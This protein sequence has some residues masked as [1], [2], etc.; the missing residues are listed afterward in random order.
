VVIINLNK[1]NIEIIMNRRQLL[2]FSGG[3]TFATITAN[4]H[5]N[6]NALDIPQPDIEMQAITYDGR[7]L[8]HKSLSQLY[9]LDLND[10]PLPRIAPRIQA[11]TFIEKCPSIPF[12]IALKL[13]VKGFGNVALYA[14]NQG[15]GYS[16]ADFPLNLNLAFAQT[17]IYRV[18]T[19]LSQWQQQGF[20]FP[21]SI[22]TRIEKAED[23]L[24]KAQSAENRIFIAKWCN[25]SLVESLWAG[26]EAVFSQSQQAIHRQNSRPNFLFGCNFF[27]H[28]QQGAEYDRKFQEL[29]NFAT[30]PFY[31]RH[32][33]PQAGQP[34]FLS[35]DEQ[36]NWLNQAKIIPKGHP[37]VWFHPI[38]IPEWV[39]GKTYQEMKQLIFQRVKNIT[40][41]Y[42]QKIPYYDIINEPH[43]ISWAN[44][45]NYS[46]E[47][48]LELTQIAAEASRQGNPEVI[49]I[50]NN[51][52]LWAQNVPY[53]K[54][55][56]YSPYSYL[57]ACLAAEIPFEVIGLQLYYPDQDMLEINRLLERFSI[58]G[59]PIHITELG[60]SSGTAIDETAFLKETTGLWHQPWSETVQAEWIEQF[61]TLCYSKLYIKAISW[62]D[63]ID[64]QFWPHGGLLRQDLTP[65]PSFER[66]QQLIKQWSIVQSQESGVRFNHL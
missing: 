13:A 9:F 42:G 21:I 20:T 45:L 17:R 50:I 12:A 5:L 10:E 8:D 23:Y 44:D 14:D 51:C 11:G 19:A 48:F 61:Y 64:G 2:Q 34:N 57:K 62:W 65:K 60:V 37:L 6:L 59:K 29:F 56:Q 39:R 52:C 49:R 47:Q 58:L 18:K 4:S 22:T 33:E 66:L 43:G 30:V 53:N 36:V 3:L 40:A 24:K 38:G 26:E 1:I 28:P 54:P 63:L 35:L 25:D 55:P 41:H 31:W 46:Q 7:I 32:F 27:G 16:A 15:K